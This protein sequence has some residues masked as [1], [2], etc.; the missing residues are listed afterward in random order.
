WR[1]KASCQPATCLHRPARFFGA[2]RARPNV[3]A[4]DEVIDSW[5]GA[6]CLPATKT[7]CELRACW[8]DLRQGYCALLNRSRGNSNCMPR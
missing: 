1:E 4:D 8:L 5:N 3:A 2:R 6:A 7:E